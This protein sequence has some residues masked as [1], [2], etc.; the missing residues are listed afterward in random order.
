M[1]DEFFVAWL[2]ATTSQFFTIA[3]IHRTAKSL[4][5]I[6]LAVEKRNLLCPLKEKHRT[7]PEIIEE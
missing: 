1:V 3:L 6:R 5:H 4:D 7:Q 2:I